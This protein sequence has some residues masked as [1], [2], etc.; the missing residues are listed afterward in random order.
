[1]ARSRARARRAALPGRDPIDAQR[2]SRGRRARQDRARD[3]R[4][5]DGRAGRGAVRALLRQRRRDAALPLARRRLPRPDRRR[6]SAA[7]ALAELRA[8]A[9]LAGR[10]RR[11]RRR[12]VRRVPA[13]PSTG[14]ANQGWK[15][16]HDSIAHADGSLASGPIALCEVQAYVY[17]AKLGLARSL[18]RLGDASGAEGLEEDAKR[19]RARFLDAFWCPELNTYALALDGAKRPCRVRSSNAGHAL[20]AGIATRDH[21]ALVGETLLSDDLFSGWGVRTLGASSG[22]STPC[23]TTTARS[24]RTT[25]LCR[26]RAGH[27]LRR[28]REC[29]P[30]PVGRFRR[31]PPRRR[32]PARALCGFTRVPGE[33]PSIR[34]R[35]RAGRL[36]ACSSAAV[37]AGSLRRR[38]SAR[39]GPAARPALV[40]RLARDPRARS[41]RQFDDLL[42]EREGDHVDQACCQ[43][44]DLDLVVSL[45][46]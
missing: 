17:G 20:F 36:R 10:P 28:D 14:L 46:S 25:T 12:R 22:A 24:G 9:G 45:S 42:C 41:R 4:R 16:S 39:S 26:A 29:E 15:D 44:G 13:A 32:A 40:R 38:A 31:E 11:S 2:S 6:R 30:H 18:R 8:R 1:M 43:T 27:P 5:R 7:R 37:G 35:A 21:A 34:S 23:R 3:A 33:G 19:L